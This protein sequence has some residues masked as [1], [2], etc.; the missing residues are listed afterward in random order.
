MTLHREEPSPCT[1]GRARLLAT[2]TLTLT[3]L[4]TTIAY[5]Q[6]VAELPRSPDLVREPA[7]SPW[8]RLASRSH[9]W[10]DLLAAPSPA[11][12][13]TSPASYLAFIRMGPALMHETDG[14]LIGML[15]AACELST[16][17]YRTCGLHVQ[18][19][20]LY[21]LH[22]LGVELG[23]QASDVGI[24]ASASLCFFVLCI[25]GRLRSLA[26]EDHRFAMALMWTV[27][28]RWIWNLATTVAAHKDD[29]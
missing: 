24:G 8:K 11:G 6:P 14:G 9:T 20:D 13:A 4:G 10:V 19:M 3:M 16:V 29:D 15:Y 25:E 21:R 17:S 7:R 22:S 28:V 18:L 1:A 5:A 23:A 26:D 2:V 12:F 27:P